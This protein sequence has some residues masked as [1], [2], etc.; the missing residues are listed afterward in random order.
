LKERFPD[1]QNTGIF[2]QILQLCADYAE[3]LLA[4][5]L[6]LNL[7]SPDFWLFMGVLRC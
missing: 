3:E 2:I 4:E 7:A 5:A 6:E 1:Y